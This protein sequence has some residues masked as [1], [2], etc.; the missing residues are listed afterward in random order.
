MSEASANRVLGPM[1]DEVVF[2]NDRVRIWELTLAPGA[3]SNL[4]E[5]EHD[6]VLVILGGDRVAA[7]Q[8]PDSDSSLPPYF[9][10]DVTPGSAVFVER[11]GIEIARNVGSE[12]YHEFI[13][14][15]KG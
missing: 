15:L 3:D 2:E 4:H 1:G 5:H 11:G 14:E 8:E 7:V 6:Y 12:P 9:E 13:I 10:A